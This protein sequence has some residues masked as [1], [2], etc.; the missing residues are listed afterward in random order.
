MNCASAVFSMPLLSD[1]RQVPRV[2]IANSPRP[3]DRA[4]TRRRAARHRAVPDPPSSPGRARRRALATTVDDVADAAGIAARTVFRHFPTRDG[5]FAAIRE[6]MRR[7]ALRITPPRRTMTSG[8]GCSTCCWSPTSSMPPTGAST[9]S[10]PWTRTA[11]PANWPR[12]P[13]SAGR[14]G[15]S[16]RPGSRRACGRPAGAAAS[17]RRGWATPS[18]CTLLGFTTQ[19]L[20][21]DFGRTPDEV[22]TLSAQVLEAALAA[23]LAAAP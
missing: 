14:A 4:V 19:S 6:G 16:S 21:G 7:Y 17:R 20:T 13:P 10:W 18:P 12:W 23:A 11:S 15:G 1:T 9:G 22:A 5:L 8:P 2:P 3:G